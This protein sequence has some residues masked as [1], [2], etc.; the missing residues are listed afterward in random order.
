VYAA[1]SHGPLLIARTVS[2]LEPDLKSK[3][4]DGR[5][6]W[7][8]GKPRSTVTAAR[9]AA[10]LRRLNK[11]LEDSSRKQVAKTLGISD[12]QVG[13]IVRGHDMPS[14]RTAALVM[15]RL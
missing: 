6:H 1:G 10:V 4:T 5:G 15:G 14:E 3:R 12:T 2:C 8:R 7:A 13:R 11:A 9:A